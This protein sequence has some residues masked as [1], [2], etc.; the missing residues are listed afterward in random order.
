MPVSGRQPIPDLAAISRRGGS[1]QLV[2]QSRR[3]QHL[4]AE[5]PVAATAVHP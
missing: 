1:S 5:P 2:T 3:L 4:L